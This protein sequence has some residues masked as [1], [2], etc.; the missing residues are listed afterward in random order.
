MFSKYLIGVRTL[1]DVTNLI[2]FEKI[3]VDPLNLVIDVLK[4]LLMEALHRQ[5][6]GI[7]DW[8]V[9]GEHT[10]LILLVGFKA[11]ITGFFRILARNLI[12]VDKQIQLLFSSNFCDSKNYFICGTFINLNVI[13]VIY[14]FN[15]LIIRIC[16][17]SRAETCCLSIWIY[18]LF[19]LTF[20]N[21]WLLNLLN[22]VIW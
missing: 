2:L 7:I 17:L 3:V 21:F 8:E 15:L 5:F 10:Q 11:I 9:T 16:D 22:M 20:M 18:L 14:L 13:L 6:K 19:L 12:I 1:I 4:I